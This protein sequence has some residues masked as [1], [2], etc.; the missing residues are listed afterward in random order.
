MGLK[1]T[2]ILTPVYYG[3]RRQ[4]E[5]ILFFLMSVVSE[6]KPRAGIFTFVDNMNI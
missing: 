3:D 5:G 6:L 4:E 2:L 1:G